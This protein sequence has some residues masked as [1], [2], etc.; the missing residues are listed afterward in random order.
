MP[1]GSGAA[2]AIGKALAAASAHLVADGIDVVAADPEVA[3]A[4]PG[5]AAALRE[6]GFHAIDEIQ[7]SRHRRGCRC[8]PTATLRRS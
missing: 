2:A 1:D 8:P 7:P 5:Y 6:A 4:H 3:A